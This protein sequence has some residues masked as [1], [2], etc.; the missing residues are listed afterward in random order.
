MVTQDDKEDT[1]WSM[2]PL[3][4]MMS[5]S[6]SPSHQQAETTSGGGDGDDT[7]TS[8]KDEK[9]GN[10][11]IAALKQMGDGSPLLGAGFKTLATRD[12]DPKGLDFPFLKVLLF[13]W[14]ITTTIIYSTAGGDDSHW[15]C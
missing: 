15:W 4:M 12:V 5:S 3:P 6:L 13:R 14:G 1:K 7:A 2:L 8:N 10:S 11:I 9:Q